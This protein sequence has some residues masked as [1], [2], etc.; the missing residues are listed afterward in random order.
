M[1]HID[2]KF[3]KV[4]KNIVACSKLYWLVHD[5]HA[6]FFVLFIFSFHLK[7]YHLIS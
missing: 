3:D 1:H 5:L 2:S 7:D 4:K 6:G